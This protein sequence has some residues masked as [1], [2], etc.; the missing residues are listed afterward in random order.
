M[1]AKND[2]HLCPGPSC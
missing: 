1:K 2:S